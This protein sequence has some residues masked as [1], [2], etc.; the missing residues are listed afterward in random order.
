MKYERKICSRNFKIFEIFK[1]FRIINLPISISETI[2]FFETVRR[3]PSRKIR[4]TTHCHFASLSLAIRAIRAKRLRYVRYRRTT[5]SK[6]IRFAPSFQEGHMGCA[7]HITISFVSNGSGLNSNRSNSLDTDC[8]VPALVYGK[9]LSWRLFSAYSVR[10]GKRDHSGH[11]GVISEAF[12][13]HHS[14]SFT[15]D[16][17]YDEGTKIILRDN[18]IA[19]RFHENIEMRWR[20]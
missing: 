15:V 8:T 13:S 20:L 6:S 2:E 9:L 4:K 12:T 1:T 10:G 14:L 18:S 5:V 7:R 17:I 19:S 11:L 3:A 16:T